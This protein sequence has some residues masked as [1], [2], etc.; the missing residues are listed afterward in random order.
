[1]N[2]VL[3]ASSIIRRVSTSCIRAKPT[4]CVHSNFLALNTPSLLFCPSFFLFLFRVMLLS[5]TPPSFF[6]LSLCSF[7]IFLYQIFVPLFVIVGV[8]QSCRYA[9]I[10]VSP[11]RVY[12]SCARLIKIGSVYPLNV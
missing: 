1:M 12:N 2:T 11:C 10:M 3:A 5:N 4:R 8:G 7:I 6:F 9:K